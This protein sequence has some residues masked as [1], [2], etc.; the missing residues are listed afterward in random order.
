[1]SN[2][3]FNP[4]LLPD[5]RYFGN[6]NDNKPNMIDLGMD[7]LSFIPQLRFITGISKLHKLHKL[8][9]ASK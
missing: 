4:S 1:M 5:P 9:K 8:H 6:K 3:R 7:A 2:P